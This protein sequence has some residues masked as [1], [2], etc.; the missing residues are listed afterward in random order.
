MLEK[1]MD[2]DFDF[3]PDGEVEDF[4]PT[5]AVVRTV[6]NNSR[7]MVALVSDEG[8]DAVEAMMEGTSGLSLIRL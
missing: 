3:V 2:A 5:W 8:E 4:V 6:G 7:I 1:Y